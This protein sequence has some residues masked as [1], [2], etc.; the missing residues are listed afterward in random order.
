MTTSSPLSI[1]VVYAQPVFWSMGEGRGAAIFTLL[2]EALA[3]R[4]HEVRVSLP[5]PSG[6]STR[7]DAPIEEGTIP[8]SPPAF[9]LHRHPAPR[10]Y[11]PDPAQP[12]PA[13]LADRLDCWLRYQRE[14][15]AAARRLSRQHPPDLVIGM[16]IY[17]APVGRRLARALGVPN[18]TRIFGT[19]LSLHLEQPLRFYANFPEVIALCTPCARLIWNDDGA[20]GRAVARRL[21]LP[22]DRIRYLRNGVDFEL[23]HPGPAPMELRARLGLRPQQKILMTGTRLAPEKKLERAIDGLRGAVALGS[24]AVLILPGDGPERDRL[25]AIARDA[26]LSDRVLFPGPIRQR[27]MAAWYRLADLMLSLLDRTNAANPVYEAMACACP[28]VALDAGTTRDVVQ[29]GET[30]VILPLAELPRLGTI[31]HD[32][33]EDRNRR[34]R[35]GEAAA[36]EIRSLILPL[37]RRMAMEVELIEEAAEAHSGQRDRPSVHLGRPALEGQAGEGREA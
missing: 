34:L 17:E 31:L 11:V 9:H 30:G 16:G 19:S 26:G 3:R 27:E 8:D 7:T 22:D 1:L 14:G 33:L 18:I 35:L 5:V 21:R 20:D 37:D 32:L 6:R 24:D 36:R 13:R 12:L 2:P 4:G 25:R 29:D 10:G 15:Y 23:F 28:V